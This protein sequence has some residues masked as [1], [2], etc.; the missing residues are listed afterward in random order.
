VNLLSDIYSSKAYWI[1]RQHFYKSTFYIRTK[2][3][4]SKKLAKEQI[5]QTKS[6]LNY[7]KITSISILKILMMVGL[8]FELEYF[9]EL[10]WNSHLAS[11]PKW[12]KHLQQIT[13]KPI[14]PDDGDN[15]L[16]LIS[17]IASVAGVTLALFYTILATLAS[18]AYA[19]VHSSIRNLL[20]YDKD[21]QGYLRRLTNVTAFAIIMLLA[22]SLHYHA[23]NLVLASLVIYSLTT[24]YGILKMGM[25]IYNFFEPSTVAATVIKE[26]LTAIN[27]VTIK[28]DYW[29]DSSFQNYYYQNASRQTENLHLIIDLCLKDPDFKKST[30]TS[31]TQSTLFTL[32]NYIDL[33]PQIPEDSRWFPFVANH[34]SYFETDMSSRG[35]S[36]STQTYVRPEM[37]HNHFWME[38]LIVNE[39]SVTLRQVL[40]TTDLQLFASIVSSYR[41]LTSRLSKALDVKTGQALIAALFDQFQDIKNKEISADTIICYK[42]W[43]Y[44]LG[45]CEGLCY[46]LLDFQ[47][48]VIARMTEF[49]KKKIEDEYIKIK[50]GETD[51]IY[52]TDLIPDLYL[53]LKDYNKFLLNEQYVEGKE[54]TPAWYIKQKLISELLLK[55]SYKFTDTV[56]LF[57]KYLLRLAKHYQD[58]NNTLVASFIIHIGLEILDKFSYRLPML[59]QTVSELDA[60]ELIKGEF[61]W[62]KID[63]KQVQSM[64]SDYENKCLS[65]LSDC[66]LKLSLVKWSNE[67]PD[68]Y[69]R[70]YAA[71]AQAINSCYVNNNL[72]FFKKMFPEFLRGVIIGY[73]NFRTQFT[74]YHNSSS[75]T[76]QTLTDLMEISGYAYLYSCIYDEWDYWNIVK[77]AWNDNFEF[78][79]QNIT[80][81]ISNQVYYKKVLFGTGISFGEKHKRGLAFANSCN[82]VRKKHSTIPN[83]KDI[84]AETFIKDDRGYNLYEVAE[85]FIELHLFTFLSAKASLNLME[86]RLFKNILWKMSKMQH[87]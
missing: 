86:R 65:I 64:L 26:I 79:E 6:S 8:L 50:W 83:D 40:K 20:I 71:L 1:T 61:I 13:P 35:L 62:K 67:F 80:L 56:S 66:F 4:S 53:V 23:G 34:K 19:K 42:D 11:F 75:V 76:Y 5:Y 73:N 38:E 27:E 31:L 3:F 60:F 81:L 44:H 10:Y 28:G 85:I 25:G 68:I 15:V 45:V 74:Q 48:G 77:G 57:D 9:A 32:V 51:T 46:N 14:Y 7:L 2:F 47:M 33:K 52:S 39:L 58:T 17:V 55:F 24:L 69:G 41:L 49:S 12:L 59:E 87:I 30:F 37:V 84:I 18:T 29:N 70:S 82:E 43:E 63:F 36:N 21:T 22:L 54:I 72:D 78:T 16:Y